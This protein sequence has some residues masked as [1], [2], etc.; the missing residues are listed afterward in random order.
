MNENA[1]CLV[2]FLDMSF[3]V[4]VTCRLHVSYWCTPCV[5]AHNLHALLQ[6]SHIRI[7]EQTIVSTLKLRYGQYKGVNGERIILVKIMLIETLCSL[8]FYILKY[9][10]MCTVTGYV[11]IM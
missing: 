10:C 3:P 8:L 6:Y 11:G 1:V 2:P 7:D 5:Y 4:Q 9:L